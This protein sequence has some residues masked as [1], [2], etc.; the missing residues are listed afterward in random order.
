MSQENETR[1]RIALP[2]AIP[3]HLCD[4]SSACAHVIDTAKNPELKPYC[5]DFQSNVSLSYITD[6]NHLQNIRAQYQATP[7]WDA[8]LSECVRLMLHKS[9]KRQ[10]LSFGAG[11]AHGLCYAGLLRAMASS[12]ALPLLYQNMKGFSGCSAGAI[13]ALFMACKAT[14]ET[15]EY[16]ATSLDVLQ[17]L[18]R[19]IEYAL[20]MDRPPYQSVHVENNRADTKSVTQGENNMTTMLEGRF[21]AK[22]S[23]KQLSQ[24]SNGLASKRTDAA[25]SHFQS[26]TRDNTSSN[27]TQVICPA[28]GQPLTGIAKVLNLEI[29]QFPSGL[30][31]GL[32]LTEYARAALQAFSGDPDIT[33]F[34]L[35]KQTQKELYIVAADLDT[36]GPVYFSVYTTP[37]LPVHIALRASMSMPGV[38]PPV[39]WQGKLLTDGGLADAAAQGATPCQHTITFV[40]QPSQKCERSITGMLARMASVLCHSHHQLVQNTCAHTSTNR[41]TWPLVIEIPLAPFISNTQYASDPDTRMRCA[42]WGETWFALWIQIVTVTCALSVCLIKPL[43]QKR[44]EPRSTRHGMS[45]RIRCAAQPRKHITL[46]LEINNAC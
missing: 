15:V 20:S 11:G 23:T 24:Q 2:G 9:S 46:G 45:R 43:C 32:F 35:Y 1:Y 25:K 42:L 8:Y 4:Y 33:F 16:H 12:G 29:N 27:E 6:T 34:E 37:D 3:K 41:R 14:P 13:A 17:L 21:T 5:Y 30:L 28:D 19:D 44:Q 18:E 31:C 7:I 40:I 22:Q 36:C 26:S 38:F 10:Y 39:E